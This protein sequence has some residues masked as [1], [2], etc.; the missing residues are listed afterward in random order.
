M[1]RLAALSAG[2]TNAS[3]RPRSW[4]RRTSR[5]RRW[6]AA[7]SRKV[8]PARSTTRAS[9]PAAA[10]TCGPASATV[11]RVELADEARHHDGPA[12]G[13]VELDLEPI[14]DRPSPRARGACRR[15][16]GCAPSRTTRPAVSGETSTDSIKLRMSRRPSPRSCPVALRPPAPGVPNS[17]ADAIAV[18]GRLERESRLARL[19]GV[20]DGVGAR[21]PGR[22]HDVV[23]VVALDAPAREPRTS[24]SAPSHPSG[25]AGRV[26]WSLAEGTSF[27]LTT[28]TATSSPR[29]LSRNACA[30][31]RGRLGRAR[32]RRDQLAQHFEALLE[33]A[34][35]PL[36]HPSV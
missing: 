32:R 15:R 14:H 12:V 6:T 1:T 4:N 33:R 31:Y 18:T 13:P 21:L 5:K 9:S 23:R 30:R 26:S 10:S 2:T 20:L 7:L 29:S 35:A 36:D 27:R 19:L 11:A 25:A 22:Q 17:Q 24:S 16:T 3:R 34:V 28:S 8:S